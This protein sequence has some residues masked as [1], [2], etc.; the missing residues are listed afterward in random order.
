ML[1]SLQHPKLGMTI[2][3]AVITSPDQ[4]TVYA[5]MSYKQLKSSKEYSASSKVVKAA[6]DGNPPVADHTI[7]PRWNLKNTTRGYNGT[8][9]K[10]MDHPNKGPSV[11]L[12]MKETGKESTISLETLSSGAQAY[13]KLLGGA[14]SIAQEA[15]TTKSTPTFAEETWES[16]Q[17]GKSMQA[18]FVSLTGDNITLK[19][20]NGQT[21]TFSTSHLSEKSRQRAEELAE[22]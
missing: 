5:K 13:A 15:E 14:S 10:L 22:Q 16:A 1:G 8:F 11:V 3:K 12:K 4:M 19:K 20:A 18:T 21:V 7:V 6:L 9:I 2:P 17:N